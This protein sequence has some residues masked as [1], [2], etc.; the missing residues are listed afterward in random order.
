MDHAQ[1]QQEWCKFCSVLKST[2][3]AVLCVIFHKSL[4]LKKSATEKVTKPTIYL[5]LYNFC[6]SY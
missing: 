2:S 6:D 3:E 4:C 5:I 1:F